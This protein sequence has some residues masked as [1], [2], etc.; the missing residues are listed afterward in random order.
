M[1]SITVL[2]GDFLQGDGDYREGVLTLRTPLYPW[3]GLKLPLRKFRH[4]EVANEESFNN[5]QQAIGYG[6]AGAMLL[7]PIGAFAG[8]MLAQKETEVTFMATL[9]DGRKLL[10]CAD[11]DT[12]DEISRKMAS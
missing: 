8:L 11:G 10:A 12:F 1:A 2:A 6:V 4:L 9:K 7:G 5:I 3:P